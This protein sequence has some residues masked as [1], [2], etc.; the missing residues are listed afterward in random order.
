VP[1]IAA[2]EPTNALCARCHEPAACVLRGTI[3]HSLAH[4]D[5]PLADGCASCH[6]G[7]LEHARAGGRGDLVDALRGRDAEHQRAVCAACHGDEPALRHAARGAHQR[8]DVGCLTCHSPAAPAHDVR[9]D[10]ERRCLE[11]HRDVAAQFALPNRHPVPDGAMGCSDCHNAHDARP[12]VRDRALREGS[13]VRCHAQYRGPFVFAHQASR[14]D[15]CVI[16][17]APHGA[18]NR[19]MLTHATSQQT[20]LQCH[21]DF[22]AFHDQTP[23][24]VFTNCLGCHTE[25]HGSNHSRFLFR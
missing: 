16:C 5:R 8:H 13:C 19:R 18:T 22:P 1:A 17:H 14:S 21:A 10:A 3:H 2:S 9:G 25:V 15:G 20:C 12:K 7:A 11:C 4:R 6:A 23:G 24:A